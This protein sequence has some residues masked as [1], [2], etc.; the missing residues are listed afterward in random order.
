MKILLS[1]FTISLMAISAI[2]QPAWSKPATAPKNNSGSATS[3]N[4]LLKGVT[5]TADQRAKIGAI[6]TRMNNKMIALLTPAQKEVLRKSGAGAVQL[7]ATQKTQFQQIISTA[8]S[9]IEAILT[10]AQI[11]QIKANIQQQQANGQ[12]R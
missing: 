1:F 7:T 10:P 9:E 6:Q 8:N 12:R 11:K 4:P 3:S 5:F 2:G